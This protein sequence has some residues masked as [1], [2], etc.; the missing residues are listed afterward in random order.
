MKRIVVLLALGIGVS[1]ADS[2]SNLGAVE[3]RAADHGQ[4]VIVTNSQAEQWLRM[5]QARLALTD[6]KIDVHIVRAADLNPDTL[7]H[8]KWNAADHTASIK[9]LSPVD[10]DLPADQIPA[11]MERTVVHELVHLQLSVLPRNGSKVVEEVVVNK[12][13]EALLQLD[14]GDNYAARLS[15]GNPV[16][17][18]R[19]GS[20]SNQASRSK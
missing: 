20:G 15:G 19:S 13:T 1:Q 12:L 14:H 8:L 2:V 11:D 16:P 5:W 6:W 3:Q 10:Y 7:G 9:V 4:Q 18:I 17:K